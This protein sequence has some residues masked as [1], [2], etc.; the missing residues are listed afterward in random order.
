MKN[1]IPSFDEFINE[2]KAVNEVKGT[3]T[4]L[5]KADNIIKS[6]DDALKGG[7]FFR[8]ELYNKVYMKEGG[9]RPVSAEKFRK[10]IVLTINNDLKDLGNEIEFMYDYTT[11]TVQKKF[12]EELDSKEYLEYRLA[13][14]FKQ[15]H[16]NS[17]QDWDR[18]ADA[19]A[20]GTYTFKPADNVS[21]YVDCG[22][23]VWFAKNYKI[24]L[25][26]FMHK[27]SYTLRY[28]DVIM[29]S[30]KYPYKP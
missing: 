6:V 28:D 3:F 16:T 17:S 25:K 30:E 22:F 13:F 18:A 20:A 23:I 27:E 12:V 2:S 26:S 29:Y 1:F 5:A 21:P 4:S 11:F 24:D 19:E 7:I 14:L 9:K 15:M 10:S 8:A